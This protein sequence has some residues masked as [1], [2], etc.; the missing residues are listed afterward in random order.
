MKIIDIQIINVRY[1]YFKKLVLTNK[2]FK[3]AVSQM[4]IIEK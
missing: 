2:L 4:F 3:L 1:S